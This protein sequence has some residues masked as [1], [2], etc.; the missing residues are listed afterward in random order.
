[1][2]QIDTRESENLRL[3]SR[4][5]ASLVEGAL[6]VS[7]RHLSKYKAII[8]TINAPNFVNNTVYPLTWDDVEYAPY[9]RFD[10]LSPDQ[11]IYDPP[12]VRG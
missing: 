10:E 11:I 2:T 12:F 6:E 7:H 1:M 4:D 9:Y 8:E 3:G 5:A